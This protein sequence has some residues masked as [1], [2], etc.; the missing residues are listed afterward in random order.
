MKAILRE[1]KKELLARFDADSGENRQTL[2]VT[3]TVDFMT[4]DGVLHHQQK[5]AHLPA[6]IDPDYYQRQADVMQADIDQA[7]AAATAKALT[8]Q[9]EVVADAALNK[10]QHLVLGEELHIHEE[11]Q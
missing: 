1:A 3:A 5:Y 4:D 7:A 9:Q 2:M 11:K 6:D 8:A 10:I